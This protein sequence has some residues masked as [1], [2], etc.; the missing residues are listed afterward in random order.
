MTE[1]NRFA[2][3]IEQ[4]DLGDEPLGS[5]S[6]IV[7]GPVSDFATDFDHTDERWANDPYPIM[8]DLHERCRSRTPTGTAERG[9]RRATTT[10][11]PSRMTPSGS[12]AHR[13]LRQ[14]PSAPG[15][16]A[17]R[18]RPAHLVRSAL[19]PRL[20]R[21]LLPAFAPKA[22]AAL[23]AGARQYC[24]E[25]LDALEG[26]DVVDAATEYAQHIPVRVIADMLGFP[27][28]DGDLFRGFI[29][30]LLEGI[31]RPVEE[32]FDTLEALFGYLATQMDAHV[33]RPRDDL[34]SYLLQVDVD[35]RNLDQL[36]VTGTMG[37]L[38]VAGIDTTWSA[39]GSSIWH[40]ATH[41]A[42]RQRLV[43]DPGLLPVAM[44]ELLRADAP[45]TMARLV[46]DDMELLPDEGR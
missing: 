28:E 12:V 6:E 14:P 21:L 9:C 11:P 38:L 40:L 45:V 22:I 5:E 18:H 36:E 37:L 13:D 10:S 16:G 35:G 41:P 20:R 27:P 1:R 39:I 43:A 32:R 25:L 30:E 33:E 15:A 4:V 3:L 44:E 17:R 23:E 29:N 26:R 46:K 42:D 2:E 19:P 24:N 31:N 7:E 34:T 8:A